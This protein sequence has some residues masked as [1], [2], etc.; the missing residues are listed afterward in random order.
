M[1]VSQLVDAPKFQLYDRSNGQSKGPVCWCL[2]TRDGIMH[3]RLGLFDPDGPSRMQ[4]YVYF[5]PQGNRESEIASETH[6]ALS[7]ILT[8]C[9]KAYC[10]CN[11]RV[12]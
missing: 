8:T 6:Y 5:K 4:N 12:L 11:C 10:G 2:R 3:K 1:V 7:R 9:G